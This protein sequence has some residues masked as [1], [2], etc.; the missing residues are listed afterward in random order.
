V[1]P[2]VTLVVTQ[3]ERMMRSEMSL[4]NVLADQS[5][6]FKLIYVDGGAPEP[7]R[8]YLE[9]RVA[10]VGGVLIRRD[11]WLWPSIGRNLAMPHVD[12]PYVAFIDNDLV[13]EPGWLRKLVA[14]AE[15][16]GAALVGPI[17]L[18]SDGVSEPRIH[19]AGGTVTRVET[20]AGIALHERHDKLNA[21]VAERSQLKRTPVDF[22]E[23]H[24]VLARTDFLR[25]TGP[26]SEEIVCVHEHIDIALE[27]AKAGLPVILEPAAAVNQHAYAPY[28]LSDIAFH[29]W[30]WQCE[31]AESSLA[32]FCAKWNLTDDGKAMEGIRGFVRGQLAHVDPLIPDHNAHRASPLSATDVK[33]SLYGL[34]TQAFAQGYAQSDLDAFAKAHAAA[35]AMF[36][37]GFRPCGRSFIAHCIGTASALAAFGFA[38]RVVVAG[39]LHAAY[40][41]APLGPQPHVAL[42]EL[43]NRM[44]ATFGART[45]QLIRGY[46]RFQLAPNA[47]REAHPSASLTADDAEIVA[48]AIANEIDEWAAG[49]FA[50][51]AKQTSAK[52]EWRAYFADVAKA[53][54]IP[55]FAETLAVLASTGAPEGFTMR[56]PN[57]ESFRLVRTGTAPM[58]HDAFRGWDQSQSPATAK[59]TA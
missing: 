21:P 52:P 53:L 30:R 17:Y 19:M 45:A 31:A 11:E 50:F 13:V 39:L 22:L 44:R 48:L 55:A 25:R 58:A 26:L 12:T 35:A 56:Q 15:E 20:P 46:A 10:E 37:G 4:E 7:V 5:E 28:A 32:A 40:S 51:S 57:K 29:R 9:R 43:E 41:H 1:P 33:Q 23:Y 2:K 49:E 14:A 36:V 27:A 8:A 54:G 38:P 34:L 24:C 16:T 59:K 47:W 18:I 6:P 3:R 42:S